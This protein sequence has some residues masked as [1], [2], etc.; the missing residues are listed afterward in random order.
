[1]SCQAL[2][3]HGKNLNAY[4]EMNKGDSLSLG[5]VLFKSLW[6]KSTRAES[7]FYDTVNEEK[8][9]LLIT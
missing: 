3:R 7:N 6:L 4:Y 2:K 8:S 1:M 5:V 9:A